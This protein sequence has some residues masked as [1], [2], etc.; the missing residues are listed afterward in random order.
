ML[1]TRFMSLLIPAI[2]MQG[3]SHSFAETKTYQLEDIRGT[4]HACSG[5]YRDDNVEAWANKIARDFVYGDMREEDKALIKAEP[6]K[7]ISRDFNKQEFNLRIGHW[8]NDEY[9]RAAYRYYDSKFVIIFGYDI[10]IR[11]TINSVFV[12]D[13]YVKLIRCFKDEAGGSMSL[14]DRIDRMKVEDERRTRTLEAGGVKAIDKATGAVLKL[15]TKPLPQPVRAPLKKVI[16]VTVDA[17]TRN[18]EKAIHERGTSFLEKARADR[19]EG[20]A[21]CNAF[22]GAGTC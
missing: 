6:I 8:A 18:K 21:R 12:S 4:L 17:E 5:D 16:D 7:L 11:W 2:L 13:S 19:L 22:F 9:G 10:V 20:N 15:L 14:Q 1:R 3:T